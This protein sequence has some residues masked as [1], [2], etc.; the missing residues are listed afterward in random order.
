MMKR[1]VIFLA[2]LALAIPTQAEVLVNGDFEDGDTGQITGTP[3]PGWNAWNWSGWHH[4]DAGAVIDTKAMKLWWDDSGLYQDFAATPGLTYDFSVQC[5]D[6]SGDTSPINWNGLIKAE[7]Y[8]PCDVQ[9]ANVELERFDSDI[10]PDDVWTQIG[11]SYEAPAGTA[12]GRIVLMVVDWH[13]GIAG[14]IQF[15]NASVTPEPTTIALLGLGGLLLRRR[16]A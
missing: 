3:I 16:R 14:A 10:E 2:L 7:F 13:D 1:L 6:W 12:Y 8:D 4:D 11:G 5:L 9:L 15:D